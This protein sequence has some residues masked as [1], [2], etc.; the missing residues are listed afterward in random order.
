MNL[1]VVMYRAHLPLHEPPEHVS[2]VSNGVTTPVFVTRAVPLPADP[3]FFTRAH[4]PEWLYILV[5]YLGQE[6]ARH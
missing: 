1:V 2:A 4:V 6:L 5:E 3:L